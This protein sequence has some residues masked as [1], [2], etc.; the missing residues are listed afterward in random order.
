MTDKELNK[1]IKEAKK[2]VNGNIW[3]R[4]HYALTRR[5]DYIALALIVSVLF[6]VGTIFPAFHDYYFGLINL[7]F[8][9]ITCILVITY[10]IIDIDWSHPLEPSSISNFLNKNTL[11]Y[12]GFIVLFSV[13]WGFILISNFIPV[14]E[15]NTAANLENNTTYVL[16]SNSCKYCLAA[17]DG[18]TK[19]VTVYND[20]HSNY[21]WNSKTVKFV[22]IDSNTKLA[23]Q[24]RDQIQVKGSVVH[25]HNGQF[26]V[27]PYTQKTKDGTPV[28]TKASHVYD[29]I[30]R[31]QKQ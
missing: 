7:V 27:L 5:S 6:C 3:T 29:Q 1:N 26:T 19:A 25:Y 30:V 22:D 28:K 4:M 24:L 8:Y 23:D 11:I 2:A 14:Q 18:A 21:L 12:R 10:L 31:V 13:V 20:I 17:K 16:Y 15:T 9:A